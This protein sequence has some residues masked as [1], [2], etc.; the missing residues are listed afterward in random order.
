MMATVFLTAAGFCQ[1]LTNTENIQEVLAR[2]LLESEQATKELQAF[3]DSRI[4][5]M[6]EFTSVQAW[7]D[8]AKGLR[9]KVLREVIFR[10]KAADWRN[11]ETRVEW[12]ET[13]AGGP[14]YVIRKLRY[15]AIPGLW[16]PA[17]LYEPENPEGKLPAIL[18]FPGHEENGKAAEY[19]QI[20]NIN[21]AKRS[22][23]SLSL[24]WFA[25]GQLG[26][27]GFTHGR[28]AQVDLCGTSSLGLFYLLMSR[29]IDILV[30]HPQ[31]DPTRIGVAGLSGGGWHTILI[32][33]LDDRVAF[34]NPVSG[35]SSFHTRV[36]HFSDLGDS[37]QTAVDLAGTADYTHLTAMRA[38][39]PTLLT[40]NRRDA[41]CFGAAHALPPLVAAVQPIYAL[42]SRASNLRTH[43]NNEPGSHNF[44][45]DN[46]QQF[47]R[48]IGDVFFPGDR[49]FAREEIS[50]AS[51][52]KSAERLA[53]DLPADNSD[54]HSLALQLSIDLPDNPM[55]TRSLVDARAWQIANREKLRALL[56]SGTPR[57]L[58]AIAAFSETT[59]QFSVTHWWLRLGDDWTI[60]AVEL[61]PRKPTSTVLLPADFGRATAAAEITT[62]L[63]EGYR[64]IAVDP[65]Y[66][67]E[68]RP[69]QFDY[70]LALLVSSVGARPLGIQVDQLSAI[71][72]WPGRAAAGQSLPRWSATQR[73]SRNASDPW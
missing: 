55:P 57:P 22:M 1:E 70:L 56:R 20:R 31:V 34:A 5:R 69:H 13:I 18:N 39:R 23:F 27:P 14:G 44:E 66:T 6:P 7:R 51:E 26:V 28:S 68:S 50:V 9:E 21:I 8:Y 64:V 36:R 11:S 60:P 15:E 46:R 4:A 52:I 48:M 32:S 72:R 45:I 49:N 35:Y 73:D 38:P 40:Y 67:G 29:A 47:Y 30:S 10:G 25:G 43:V 16:V 24:D 42:Y 59:T 65:F 33:S 19:E 58:S 12:L 62:L 54:F 61:T 2:P 17:L 3:C 63:H 41:C 37:E 53:V 71:A